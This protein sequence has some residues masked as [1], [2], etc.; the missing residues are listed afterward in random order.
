MLRAG[1]PLFVLAAFASLA[2]GLAAAH[3]NEGGLEGTL[4]EGGRPVLVGRFEAPQPGP[5]II[6]PYEDGPVACDARNEAAGVPFGDGVAVRFAAN[7]THVAASF[8]V[9][10]DRP[11]FVAV[12]FDTHDASRALVLMRETAVANH[13]L[14]ARGRPPASG[15]DGALAVRT[16]LLGVPYPLPGPAGHGL[17]HTPEGGGLVL[18]YRDDAANG[19]A[20]EEAPGHVTLGILRAALPESLGPGRI[21]HAV[22]LADSE[23]PVLIPRPLD[24]STGVLQANLYLARPGE[25]PERI[26]EALTTGL[27]LADAL[28]IALVLVGAAAVSRKW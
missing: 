19:E 27:S 5:L 2:A 9:P 25:D 24:G 13:A 6:V 15:A 16:G 22:A 8:E 12:A 1:R 11:A 23:V 28:P 18:Q 3:G 20:C 17:A 14:V 7:A 21:V 26:R 10:S 4:V